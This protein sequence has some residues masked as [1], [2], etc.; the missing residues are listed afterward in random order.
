MARRK[1]LDDQL[2]QAR[3]R[4]KAAQKHRDERGFDR[5]WQRF[6]DL[7]RGKC[8][9]DAEKRT[10]VNVAF[11]TINVIYPSVSVN[12]PHI[13]VNARKEQD[14]PRAI[15]TEA[16][17]NYAWRHWKYQSE[18]RR[19]IKDSLIVGHGWTKVGH[20]F[21]ED[22]LPL[23]DEDSAQELAARIAEADSYAE[24]NPD[25]AAD[26]P[27]DGEIEQAL[28]ESKVVVKEDRPFVE[29]VSFKDMLVDPDSTC[30]EDA[31]W[32]AQKMWRPLEDVKKDTDY[33]TST[34]KGVEA[35]KR[36][37]SEPERSNGQDEAKLDHT[38]NWV[39]VWEFYD[40]V[41]DEWSVFADSG[42]GF[43]RKPEKIPFGTGHPFVMFR[44]YEI[45][46][47]LY[48]VGELEMIELLAEEL[49]STREDLFRM[50]R[51]YRAKYLFRESAFNSPDAID[52]LNSTEHNVMVPVTSEES[53]NDVLVPVMQSSL[54]PDFYNQSELIEGDIDRTSGVSEYQ[55]G[56]MPEVRRTA[57]EASISADAANARSADKLS[58]VEITI[59]QIAAKVIG[60]LQQ[61]MTGEM[62]ARVVGPNGVP[63]WFNFDKDYIAGEFDFEVEAGSTQP[64]NETFR[65]QSALQ[66]VDALAP[67]ADFVNKTELARHVMESF[68]IKNAD[69]FLAPPMLPPTP[70][71]PGPAVPGGEE[72]P[73]GPPGLPPGPQPAS[74]DPDLLAQ[75]EGQVDLPAALAQRLA[76]SSPVPV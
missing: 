4:I 66:L 2:K 55:R 54:L 56:G 20:R 62:A 44:N 24:E 21:K 70:G 49:D 5:D 10:I 57:T 17:V 67:M 36:T 52:A 42:D 25:L 15:I 64:M 3:S 32:I 73:L 47:E 7:Y 11:S 50:R 33:L 12:N 76:G 43:L 9:S 27:T 34:R 61:Y 16:V 13:A 65:R 19:A 68:G 69:R 30:I 60:V 8:G 26:L 72:A 18:V 46:D 58:M 45:P 48:P 63:M 53:L 31:T 40:L 51:K 37:T 75:L 35:S 23:T 39:C 14:G 38:V 6:V 71:Q 1:P 74:V 28:P 41:N 29:R 22:K 59:G